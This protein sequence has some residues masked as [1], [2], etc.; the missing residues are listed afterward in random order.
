MPGAWK[1]NLTVTSD[2]Y[3]GG[4]AVGNFV[5]MHAT[6]AM[7]DCST[8]PYFGVTVGGGATCYAIGPLAIDSSSGSLFGPSEE[9]AIEISSNG[10]MQNGQSIPTVAVFTESNLS[11]TAAQFDLSGT[12]LNGTISG[13]W[14]CDNGMMPCGGMAGEFYAWKVQP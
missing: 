7:V 12:A 2:I 8:F 10:T 5:N 9:I 4:K 1:V 3:G 13:T 14:E 11:G 6:M